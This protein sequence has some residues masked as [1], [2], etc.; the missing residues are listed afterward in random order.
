FREI[1]FWAITLLL[2]GFSM[3]NGHFA[4]TRDGYNVLPVTYLMLEVVRGNATLFLYIV[5]TI[6]A[7]ELVWR[8]RDTHFDQIHDALPFRGWLDT[9]SK[10]AALACAQLFLLTVVMLCGILSQATAGYYNFELLQYLKELYVITFPDVLIFELLAFFVQ[11]IVSNKF[12]GHGIVVAVFALQLVLAGLGLVD[13]LYVYGDMVSYTYSDMNGY[14][15]F[16]KPLFWSTFYWLAWAVLL[17]V[18]ARL[19]ARRRP[20]LS[21]WIPQSIFIRDSAASRRQGL[22]PQLIKLPSRSRISISPMAAAP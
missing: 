6:Y 9:L 10:L 3:I 17:G 14:G 22:I 2:I 20:R 19:L 15:H 21:R 1:P 18:L 16:V 12:I 8:E 4:G 11:T 7:G 13:H 5:A